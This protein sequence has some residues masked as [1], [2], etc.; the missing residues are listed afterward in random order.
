MDSAGGSEQKPLLLEI[1]EQLSCSVWTGEMLGLDR[2][3]C[4][5]YANVDVA[6]SRSQQLGVVMDCDEERCVGRRPNDDFQGK[7][8]AANPTV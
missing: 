7:T 1:V 4:L 8:T 3:P 2:C 6:S 5:G